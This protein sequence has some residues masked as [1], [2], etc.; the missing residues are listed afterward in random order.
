MRFA[1]QYVL[2]AWESSKE[3]KCSMPVF[4]VLIFRL[5]IHFEE[6]LFGLNFIANSPNVLNLFQLFRPANIQ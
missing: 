3:Q 4:S 1:V 2:A 6:R 5:G